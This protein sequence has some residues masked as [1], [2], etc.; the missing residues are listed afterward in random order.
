MIPYMNQLWR[1]L[2]DFL[3]QKQ[4]TDKPIF[5]VDLADPEKGAGTILNLP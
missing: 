2:L 1:D 3:S 5:F 4:T